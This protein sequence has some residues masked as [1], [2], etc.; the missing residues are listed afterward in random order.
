MLRLLIII[1]TV[2]LAAWVINELIIEPTKR[3]IEAGQ[4][5]LEVIE[6]TRQR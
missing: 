4:K 2:A 1:I 6:S 3:A 5:R